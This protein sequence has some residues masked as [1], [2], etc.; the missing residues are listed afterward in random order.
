MFAIKKWSTYSKVHF[1]VS[2][3][4]LRKLYFYLRPRE[5]FTQWKFLLPAKELSSKILRR[6]VLFCPRAVKSVPETGLHTFPLS[7]RL[8]ILAPL[9]HFLP[10]LQE[11]HDLSCGKKLCSALILKYEYR[12]IFWFKSAFHA[13]IVLIPTLVYLAQDHWINCGWFLWQLKMSS[14]E[15]A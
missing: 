6:L 2:K 5:F 13:Q 4:V 9:H 7:W 11:A 15:K 10:I 12:N 3:L 1:N 8:G 14:P